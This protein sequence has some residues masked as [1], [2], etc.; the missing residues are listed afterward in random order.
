MYDDIVFIANNI[1]GQDIE[2]WIKVEDYVLEVFNESG[3][4]DHCTVFLA[5]VEDDT[6]YDPWFGYGILLGDSFIRS[7]YLIHDNEWVNGVGRLGFGHKKE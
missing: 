3:L 7:Y 5:S 6:F 2:I 4:I 1:D